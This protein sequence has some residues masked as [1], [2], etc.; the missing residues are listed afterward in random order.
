[1][2][3]DEAVCTRF[4]RTRQ[5]VELAL[6]RRG[7]PILVE[8][9]LDEV[10]AGA[11]DGVPITTYWAWKERHDRNE[12]FPGGESLDEAVQRY[13]GA[14]RRLLDRDARV[15][16]IVCHELVLRLLAG[17]SVEIGNAV[18]HLFDERSLRRAVERVEVTRAAA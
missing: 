15:T 3:I 5:T 4:L 6:R 12:R 1:V 10:D 14:V 9:G 11:L 7:V 2:R 18:P 13:A 8:P 17:S 16:L